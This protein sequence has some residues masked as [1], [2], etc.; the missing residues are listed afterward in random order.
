MSTRL[1]Q[2]VVPKTA[3]YTIVYPMDAPGTLFTNR[4]A[5][6]AVTFTLPTPSRALLGVWYEFGGVVNQNLA[7]AGSICTLNNDSAASVTASTGNQ[8]IG[9]RMRATCV[10]IAAGTFRWLVSGIGVGATYTVA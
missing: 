10:E 8:K 7:V 3:D 2:R 6:G 1:T 5:S 9:A 4:G